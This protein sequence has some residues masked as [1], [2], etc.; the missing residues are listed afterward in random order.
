MN[1][2][3]IL[4]VGSL[5]ALF[6]ASALGNTFETDD[7]RLE[8]IVHSPMQFEI[9]LF[10][11]SVPGG[12]YVLKTTFPFA[13]DRGDFRAPLRKDGKE[14]GDVKGRFLAA[15]EGVRLTFDRWPVTE[16]PAPSGVFPFVA[17]EPKETRV[18]LTLEFARFEEQEAKLN[19]AY[20]ELYTSLDPARQKA[21]VGLQDAWVQL[22]DALAKSPRVTPGNLNPIYNPAHWKIAADMTLQR[23][24]WLRHF[25]GDHVGP[26]ISGT[27]LDG[28]G[29]ILSVKVLENGEWEFV[30]DV[31]R[32]QGFE[33]GFLR[34][35]A[36]KEKALINWTDPDPKALI[37]GQ[38]AK[39]AY[40]NHENRIRV[41]PNKSQRIQSASSYFDGTYL[42]V[43]DLIERFPG[44]SE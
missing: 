28:M 6:C 40:V 8:R 42:K 9:L 15:P 10:Q 2:L 38:P 18:E 39:I 20:Q 29:G 36:S 16:P 32:G 33:R 21:L 17:P 43:T 23:I 34:G 1:T 31:T 30:L 12:G 19:Q 35:T 22:R 25:T 26:D 27:Y 7:W 3:S 14:V 13:N 4:R 37:T 24:E 44:V 11:K 41:V 5:V